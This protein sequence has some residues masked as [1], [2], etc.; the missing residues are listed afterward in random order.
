[1]M[2]ERLTLE[3]AVSIWRME[4]T[5]A[6]QD[7]LYADYMRHAEYLDGSRAF[8]TW[9]SGRP[10]SDDVGGDPTYAERAIAGE[11]FFRAIGLDGMVP[12]H[13]YHVDGTRY[14]AVEA[15]EGDE[16]SKE[17][18]PDEWDDTPDD[19]DSFIDDVGALHVS[20]M[21]NGTADSTCRDTYL[22]FAAATLLSGNSDMKGENI[23]L[24]DNGVPVGID[25]DHAGG[26]F[27]EHYE[28]SE[29][30]EE[31][32][33]E[34]AVRYLTANAELLSFDTPVQQ[35]DIEQRAQALAQDIDKV[36]GIDDVVDYISD[37]AFF[38][39]PAFQYSENIRKN[40]DAFNAGDFPERRS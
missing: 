22:T 1:M 28:T 8:V 16:I 19:N 11:Q 31:S 39:D 25:L 5:D 34:R 21:Q 14:L 30:W 20:R 24:T 9:Y 29:P 35:G 38:D 10:E 3:R 40:L 6:V 36:Y 26:D 18:K 32:H 37:S 4:D 27:T 7:T 13:H 15:V 33:Y 2:G 17:Y 12:I 23:M